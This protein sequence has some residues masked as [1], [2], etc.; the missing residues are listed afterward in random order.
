M[1]LVEHPEK[2]LRVAGIVNDSIT[3]GPG[4]R[5]ALFVQGCPH[6]C[7][8]C[9][10][11][12]THDIRG[13]H[14]AQ[15]D[16]VIAHLG[17]HPLVRGLPLSGGEPLLQKDLI[18]FLQKIRDMGLAVKLDT[19]GSAPDRLAEILRVVPP[20]YIAMDF[21]NSREKYAMTCGL[22]SFPEG[23]EQSIDRSMISGIPYEFRTT[24]V[25]ELH[26]VADIKSIA[27]R[28]AGAR[29]YYLQGFIDSGDLIGENYS[30][31]TPAEM[32]EMLAAALPYVPTAALRG[33][34][35]GD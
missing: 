2:Q 23:V 34:D 13:G 5:F 7:P 20:D 1:K 25:R 32:K 17:Q 28:I 35:T 11:P 12:Q 10:N 18:P 9:H 19:N 26:T 4:I 27:R 31:C 24:V 29:H 16:D 6:G 8:G 22:P 33:V 14:I 30:A 15:T 21:K 3:D